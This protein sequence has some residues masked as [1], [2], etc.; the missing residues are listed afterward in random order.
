MDEREI[1]LYRA[2]RAAWRMTARSMIGDVAL[3]AFTAFLAGFAMGTAG[4]AS[5]V[6]GPLAG[7]AGLIVGLTSL[8]LHVVSAF[9]RPRPESRL[10][11]GAPGIDMS[12]LLE[13]RRPWRAEAVR[14]I[15]FL[16]RDD[17]PPAYIGRERAFGFSAL[18]APS[19]SAR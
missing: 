12:E 16:D 13:E 2:D 19:R 4:F 3:G 5:A 17:E 8:L 1:S 11:S 7:A 10:P 15:R 9:E 6:A 18:T 14:P